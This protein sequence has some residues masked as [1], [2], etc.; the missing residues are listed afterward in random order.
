MLA[1]GLLAKKAVRARP[2]NRSGGQD[3]AR[4]GLAGRH[5]LFAENR[6]AEVSRSTRLQ[7][8]RLRL[9]HLHWQLRPAPPAIEKRSQTMIS[10]PPP[11]CPATA[12]S[13]PACTRTSRPT[14][15]CPRRSWSLSRSPAG[16]MSTSPRIRSAGKEGSDVYLKDIWPSLDEIRDMMQSAL[17]PETFASSIATSPRKIRNGTRSRP[18]PA[19]STSGTEEHYIQEPPFFENFSMTPGTHRRNPRRPGARHLRR[20]RHDRPHLARR[21]IKASSPAGQYLLARG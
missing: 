20:F 2:N 7:H 3:F 14:S 17:K 19:M 4:A 21:C 10:S 13:R 8:R 18:P 1:A 5:R 16:S 15:S 11:C 9:H 6:T 12:I